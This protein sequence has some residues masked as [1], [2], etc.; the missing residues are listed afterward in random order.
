MYDRRIHRGNT[1]ATPT[2]PLVFYKLLISQHSQPDPLEIQKNQE[3]KRKL[4]AKRKAESRR[5]IKTPDAVQGRKHIDVQTDL[6]LEELSDK[7]PEAIAATQTDA[8]LHRA[9]SPFIVPQKSGIDVATQV[10]EGEL[11]DFDFEVLPIL[12]IIV[13]KT[14]EQ[15]LMEVH[16]EE[17][18]KLLKKHQVFNKYSR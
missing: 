10:Y 8:F 9:P 16:E 12:E 18:L 1:Y 3:L 15:S 11:F 17:E 2:L 14:V 13:A 5:R 7:I 4:K 6:Y